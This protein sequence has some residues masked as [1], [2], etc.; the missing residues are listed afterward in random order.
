MVG[1]TECCKCESRDMAERVWSFRPGFSNSQIDRLDG[2]NRTTIGS[3]LIG[4]D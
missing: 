3:S 2:G 1:L 4:S